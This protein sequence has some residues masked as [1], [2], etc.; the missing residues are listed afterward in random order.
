MVLLS[1][2]REFGLAG[3]QPRR[4]GRAICLENDMAIDLSCGDLGSTVG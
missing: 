2:T 1:R 4:V 3:K